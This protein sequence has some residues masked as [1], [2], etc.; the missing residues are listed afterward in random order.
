MKFYLET[1]G[2]AS[3]FGNSQDLKEALMEM[4]HQPTSEAD[5][6]AVIVNTC[7]V[8]ERTE[9]KI[10]RRLAQFQGTRLV[11][12]GCLPAALPESLRRIKCR[13]S[14]GPVKRARAKE[15]A[16]LFAAAAFGWMAGQPHEHDPDERQDCCGTVNIA[17]GCNGGC[18]YC[19]VRRA[20]GRLVSRTPEEVLEAVRRLAKLGVAEVQLAAQDTAAWGSEI[21]TSL[22]EL[23][24]MVAQVPGDFMVRL[25]MM[26]PDSAI[27]IQ[28]ELIE[29]MHDPRIYRFLHMPVQ[30]GSDRILRSMGRRYSTGD[31][32]EITGA[33]RAEFAD[34]S[35]HTDVIVGFP[36][37]TDDDF[38]KTVA[39][40]S[41]LQP[42]KVNI[43]RFSRRPG[44]AAA[45]LYDM[46]DRIKKDRSR[47]LTK[48][49]LEMASARNRRYE[50]HALNVLVTERGRGGTM[51][52]RSANYAGIVIYGAPPLGRL[53]RIDVVGSNPFYLKGVLA[54]KIR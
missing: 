29:A 3:N 6:D 30:S 38:S 22:P 20:R 9:R 16:D 26:N 45:R 37:E 33:F 51:K 11:V 23:L 50:G 13:K 52:A 27:S 28:K 17:E 39:L 35:I 54:P 40:L 14:M 25:G 18:S 2:C 48:L 7:A 36:G 10:L 19:I 32:L 31:F 15:I 4:G 41:A 42:D 8:T 34:L 21:G 49:W 53:C 43:T 24:R 5:A 46:P 1:Y 44:T 47:Q 12:A